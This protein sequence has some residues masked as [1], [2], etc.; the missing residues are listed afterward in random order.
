MAL[1]RVA[2][3][4]LPSASDNTASEKNPGVLARLLSPTWHPQKCHRKSLQFG[5]R[6]L[7]QADVTPSRT[8]RPSAVHKWESVQ[9]RSEF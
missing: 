5:N 6:Q 2:F 1:N 8:E 9:I 7:D 3:A 4:P